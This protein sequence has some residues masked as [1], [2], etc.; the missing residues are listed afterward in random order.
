MAGSPVPWVLCSS[1]ANDRESNDELSEF[2]VAGS[3]LGAWS[4][5][6]GVRGKSRLRLKATVTCPAP[7]GAGSSEGFGAC[8]CDGCGAVE[9]FPAAGGGCCHA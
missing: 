9:G 5:W 2:C 6:G 3:L 7:T 1:S 4:S 8:D